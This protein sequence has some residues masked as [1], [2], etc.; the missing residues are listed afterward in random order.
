[1]RHQDLK[2]KMGFNTNLDYATIVNQMPQRNLRHFGKTRSKKTGNLLY[3]PNAL[4]H[5]MGMVR[6]ELKKQLKRELKELVRQTAIYFTT[7]YNTAKSFY[8]IK[9]IGDIRRI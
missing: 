1:M 3:D 5:F 4:F 9:K 7:P 6:L 2:L 8:S